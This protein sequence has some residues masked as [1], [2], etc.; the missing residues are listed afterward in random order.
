MK[1]RKRSKELFEGNRKKVSLRNF[2]VRLE[3]EGEITVSF[4]KKIVK[5]HGEDTGLIQRRLNWFSLGRYDKHN[6][7]LTVM[8]GKG[9]P[10]QDRVLFHQIVTDS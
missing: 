9:K 1:E 8:Q 3:E 10:L 6:W 5:E 2:F 4:L 7:H